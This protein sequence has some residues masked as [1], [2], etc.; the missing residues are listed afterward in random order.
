MSRRPRGCNSWS[1]VPTHS[2]PRLRTAP[3]PLFELSRPRS[4]REGRNQF[5]LTTRTRRRAGGAL[6]SALSSLGRVVFSDNFPRNGHVSAAGGAHLWYSRRS[7]PTIQGTLTCVHHQSQKPH[8]RLPDQDPSVRRTAIHCGRGSQSPGLAPLQ[9]A[10]V[11]HVLRRFC[12]TPWGDQLSAV[13]SVLWPLQAS[14]RA[15]TPQSLT[16]VSVTH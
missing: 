4:G 1:C 10:D 16:P 15:L 12:C 8:Q 6:S 7:P 13:A 14:V 9:G 5:G 11:I 3:F 2:W